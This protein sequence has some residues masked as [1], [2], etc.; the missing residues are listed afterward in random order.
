MNQFVK[1]RGHYLL[2]GRELL[3]PGSVFELE[4]KTADEFVRRG[5]GTFSD[6]PAHAAPPPPGHPNGTKFNG[7]PIASLRIDG[8]TVAPAAEPAPS[9]PVERADLAERI[10]RAESAV[11]PSPGVRRAPDPDPLHPVAGETHVEATGTTAAG[12]VGQRGRIGGR[13]DERRRAVHRAG[14]RREFS[15]AAD[16]RQGLRAEQPR[17]RRARASPAPDPRRHDS[18]RRH[19]GSPGPDRPG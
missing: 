3:N 7:E 12:G 8:I 1:T 5:L 15:H 17:G 10:S 14:R 19:A 9:P 11:G 4:E 16:R 13:R 18:V 6:G 2:E